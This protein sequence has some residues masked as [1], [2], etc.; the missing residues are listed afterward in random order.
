MQVKKAFQDC[1]QMTRVIRAA[2]ILCIAAFMIW[3]QNIIA[4][5]AKSNS[6]IRPSTTPSAYSEYTGY[7]DKCVQWTG[8]RQFENQD[9]DGDGRI[10]RVFRTYQK[11]TEYCHYKILFGNQMVIDVSNQMPAIGTPSIQAADINSDGKNEIIFT[12]QYDMS[13]DMRAF[14]DLIV[15]EKKGDVYVEVQLPFERSGQ[16]YTQGLT[17]HYKKKQKQ[18]ITV[19][20][21]DIAY[22][23]DVPISQE[24]WKTCFYKDHFKHTSVVSTV[25]DTFVM[26]DGEDTQLVCSVHLFDKWSNYG[27]ILK[28]SY[29]DQRYIIKDVILTSDEFA[30]HPYR[31]N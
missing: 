29:E 6:Q 19:S 16:G 30:V 5:N 26:Q 13:S 24:L 12:L 4:R 14:G 8:Y 20:L 18:L 1:K 15:Y 25:W 7:M 28:L 27:L 23:V 31:Y 21:D 3:T 2:V 22:N 9:Y 17:V 11:N 10:D